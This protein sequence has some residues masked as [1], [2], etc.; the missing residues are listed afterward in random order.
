MTI[1]PTAAALVPGWPQLLS[2]EANAS[3]ASL[4]TAMTAV[5]DELEAM[6]V[7]R[8]FY[9]STQWL[10]VLGHLLQGRARLAGVHVDETFHDGPDLNFSFHVDAA[11]AHRL[12]Q[13]GQQQGFQLQVVDYEG[14][15]VD[16]GTIVADHWLNRGRFKAMMLSSAVY[17]DHRATAQ[18][19][20]TLFPALTADRVPT[21]LIL[22]S[23]LSG[24]A[25]T[26]EIDLREDQLA[27]AAD[28]AFNQRLLASLAT[29]EAE[30]VL[31]L[32]AREG[33][34]HR[35]DMGGKALAFLAGSGAWRRPGKVRSYGALYGTGAAV[36]TFG[37]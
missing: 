1:L 6:G 22:V 15:P 32:A 28:D 35:L 2:P 29:R 20:S 11:A 26:T 31:A 3:T 16:T 14:F 24:H 17:A 33:R 27:N 30:V 8:L 19:A 13:A 37:F 12:A 4:T 5:G 9:Y 10:S 36:I 18:L 25:Y 34:A 21:A 7:K 23:G